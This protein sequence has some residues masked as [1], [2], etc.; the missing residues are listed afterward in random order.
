MDMNE[1][2]TTPTIECVRR[3]MFIHNVGSYE[4]LFLLQFFF[5]IR[6]ELIC[7][8]LFIACVQFR[9]LWQSISGTENINQTAKWKYVWCFRKTISIAPPPK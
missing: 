3:W 4:P 7:F 9:A 5:A 6:F 2:D 8:S 1:A